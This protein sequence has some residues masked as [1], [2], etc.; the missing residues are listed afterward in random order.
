MYVRWSLA[1]LALIG[2]TLACSFPGMEPS[3][4][5]PRIVADPMLIRNA[6]ITL[7]LNQATS[8][9]GSMTP[10]W[11]CWPPR[12]NKEGSDNDITGSFTVV[13]ISLLPP[14][15]MSKLDGNCSSSNGAKATLSATIDWKT[16]IIEFSLV[17]TSS[18]Q[19]NIS[20]TIVGTGSFVSPTRAEGNANWS[21]SCAEKGNGY[22]CFA[23]KASGT[24][25]W[26]M[27]F[28]P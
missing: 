15:S 27:T 25:P 14:E 6:D 5:V 18:W 19:L 10:G 7:D 28:S 4:L 17:V 8:N 22:V 13:P 2:A 3:D 23:E 21:M 16:E 26:T 1:I 9:A 20:E 24:V 11:G 12:H